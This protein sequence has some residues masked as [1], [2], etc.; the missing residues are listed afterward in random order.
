MGRQPTVNKNLP[1]RMRARV[2]RS[3]KVYYYYDTGA[4][5]RVELP[6]GSDFVS[7]VQKW[8]ELE[9]DNSPAVKALITFKWVSEKYTREEI[10]TKA[11][12][13]QQDNIKEMVNLVAFFGDAP[14]EEIEPHHVR[15]YLNSRRE[16]PVRANRE[17]ALLSH[18]F[19]KAR[20]WGITAMANPCRGITGFTEKGR[21]VY[22]EDETYKAVHDAADQP[23]RDAMD[24]AYL[25]GQRP[26]DT[27]KY[28]ERDIRDGQLS[29]TQNKT[30][31]KL[32]ISI[33]GE[34]EQ[35]IERILARKRAITGKVSFTQ[36]VV[37]ERGQ[38]LTLH[39][40][41][42]R[43]DKARDRAGIDKSRFQFRDLR[44][45]AGTD[46]AE[47]SGDMRQAQKQLGHANITMTET[48]VRARK[49]DKVGPTK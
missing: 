18:V 5:P 31:A 36:L 35:V 6:L 23:T 14:I 38:P 15:Q 27:L 1:P 33:T 7:A 2:Q 34:L 21:D 3:G 48:Y 47:S 32:R 46:K 45:K 43:F 10:P 41:Q 9:S 11:P 42:Q 8:A 29:V 19:N 26:A 39:A 13:T 17:K 44:A 28:D 37:N 20:D 24:L 12:R 16:S 22:V 30:G 40:L 49:G 25:T 4:K